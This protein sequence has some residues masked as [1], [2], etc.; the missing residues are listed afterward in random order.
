M[1]VRVYG[2]ITEEECTVVTHIVLLHEPW[3]NSGCR[4]I[5]QCL[6]DISLCVAAVC[7]GDTVRGEG[8]PRLN[9]HVVE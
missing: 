4:P 5:V 2:G 3:E 1:C 8:E 9:V 6:L 7:R